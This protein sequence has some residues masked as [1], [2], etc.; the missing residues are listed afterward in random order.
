MARLGCFCGAEMTNTV[1]PSEN[2]LKIFY[3]CEAENAIKDNP[4]IRLWDFYTGWDEKNRRNNSF[5]KRIEDVE[6]WK[7]PACKRVYEVQAQSCGNI[8]R[9]YERNEDCDKGK[10]SVSGLKELV[11]LKD[12]E[13]D[14]MLSENEGMT[15]K[16][17]LRKEKPIR[18]F[19]SEDETTVYE[20]NSDDQIVEV[21]KHARKN[22]TGKDYGKT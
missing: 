2:L 14:D 8:I 20:V 11:V 16:D 7:C 19:S 9:A 21:Y 3:Y 4:G 22:I 15:L 13:M 17:Y 1:A 6:Y 10:V 5:M 12:V 18:Y